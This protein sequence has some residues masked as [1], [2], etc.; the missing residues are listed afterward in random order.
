MGW[1]EKRGCDENLGLEFPERLS[2]ISE[3]PPLLLLFHKWSNTNL[4]I[5]ITWLG[6]A[7]SKLDVGVTPFTRGVSLI[8]WFQFYEEHYS[9]LEEVAMKMDLS[10]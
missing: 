8:Y 2:P 3:K 7:V 4:H 6:N 10:Q 1:L 5:D 9:N